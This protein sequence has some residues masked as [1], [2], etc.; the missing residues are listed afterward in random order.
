MSLHTPMYSRPFGQCPACRPSP[1]SPPTLPDLYLR[2]TYLFMSQNQQ[3]RQFFRSWSCAQ[4][5]AVEPAFVNIPG[6]CWLTCTCCS[7][8]SQSTYWRW[9]G[10]AVVSD[11]LIHQSFSHCMLVP[12]SP[13]SWDWVQTLLSLIAQGSQENKSPFVNHLVRQAVNSPPPLGIYRSS[14]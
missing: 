7:N 6:R 1:S 8:R 12:S 10:F 13:F 4:W 9:S 11:V 14:V 3:F 5:S 2:K